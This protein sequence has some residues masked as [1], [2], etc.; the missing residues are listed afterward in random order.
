MTRPTTDQRGPIPAPPA[1]APDTAGIKEDMT[2]VGK[3]RPADRG[4]GDGESYGQT[5]A[6]N[7]TKRATLFGVDELDWPG[8]LLLAVAMG[9]GV[10]LLTH[11]LLPSW[12]SGTLTSVLVPVYLTVAHWIAVLAIAG[13]VLC[14]FIDWLRERQ[15]TTP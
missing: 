4:G 6:K 9:F 7:H 8:L 5:V 14:G 11:G 1:P 2:S 3:T 15:T 13:T 10:P 12:Q